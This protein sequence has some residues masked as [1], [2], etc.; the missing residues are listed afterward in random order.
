MK[1]VEAKRNIME[2]SEDDFE[3]EVLHATLPV[4]VDFYAPWCGPCKIIAPLLEISAADFAGRL[5]FAKANVDEAPELAGCFDI[6]GVPTLML[7]RSG[8]PVDKLVGFPG[9]RQF[10]AWLDAAANASVTAST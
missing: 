1:D 8:K 9:P 7:F 3:A 5:R 10:K 6:T 2:L 4:A